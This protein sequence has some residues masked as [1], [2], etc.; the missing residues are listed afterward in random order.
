M[1]DHF[2]GKELGKFK[3]E[4][5]FKNGIF[6]RNKMYCY[7][8]IEHVIMVKKASGVDSPKLGYSYYKF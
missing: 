8:D 6:V 4:S 5:K 7:T 1:S 2:F 3:L